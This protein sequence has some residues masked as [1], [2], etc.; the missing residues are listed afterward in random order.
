MKFFSILL[1]LLIIFV[2]GFLFIKIIKILFPV[3]LLLFIVFVV[4]SLLKG[5]PAAPKPHASQKEVIKDVEIRV[6]DEASNEE[7]KT[8]KKE[9]A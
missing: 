8:F 7:S 9:K 4:T 2:L 5:K 1:S 6:V 3:L